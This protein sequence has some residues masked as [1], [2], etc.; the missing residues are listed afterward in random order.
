MSTEFSE[1]KDYIVGL[2]KKVDRMM[3][4]INNLKEKNDDV[5]K[6]I[7]K[8]KDAV[9]HPQDGL[10]ARIKDL[11]TNSK[12][13]DAYEKEIKDLKDANTA[14]LVK[15][16]TL[17]QWKENQSKISWIAI[18]AIVG[19]AMKQIWDLLMQH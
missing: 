10:Y 11:E 9:Y 5:A 14:S 6:D 1:L 16:T 8:I 17:E 12:K 3:N 18:T 2:D 19:L 7:T 4:I 13:H 15:V